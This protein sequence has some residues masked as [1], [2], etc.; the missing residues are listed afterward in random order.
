MN[1]SEFVKKLSRLSLP[2]DVI[3]VSSSGRATEVT[4]REWR[5]KP[6]QRIIHSPGLASMGFALPQAIGVAFASGRRVICIEGDGSLQLNVQ[7]L[8]LFTRY[9]LNIKLFVL[10]N[11]GYDSIRSTQRRYFN[12]LAGC[13][14]NSG[15][16]LPSI[17]DISRAYNLS[18]CDDI[19]A[20][21]T[22][23][24]PLICE[25]KIDSVN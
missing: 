22:Y 11:G 1:C 17:R 3:V 16:S 12:R 20:S 6:G 8:E 19:D 18:Y 15:L 13:D 4:L 23:D 5:V 2:T 21:F 9:E 7:E 25:V 10:N 14:K 24:N